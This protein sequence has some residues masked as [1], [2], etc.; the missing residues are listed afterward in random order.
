MGNV[1]GNVVGMSWARCGLVTT[2]ARLASGRQQSLPVAN[3]LMAYD[4]ES[5]K[6][7]CVDNLL[8]SGVC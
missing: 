2:W 8:C 6:L 4:D 1:V 5:P 3:S 7:A